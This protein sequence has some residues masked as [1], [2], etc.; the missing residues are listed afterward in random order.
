[1]ATQL[2]FSEFL[3]R[4]RARAWWMLRPLILRNPPRLLH[5][6]RSQRRTFRERFTKLNDTIIFIVPGYN[7][8]NGGI[9]SI[10]SIAAEVERLVNHHGAQVLICSFPGDPPLARFT[11]FTHSQPIFPLD[12][13]LKS[14]EAGSLVQIHIPEYYVHYFGGQARRLKRV[15]PDL[16]FCFN[17]M[18][19]NVDLAPSH[20]DVQHLAAVGVVTATTAHKA[21][22][23][24]E[25]ARKLGCRLWHWSTFISPEGYERRSLAR[26]RR[27]IVVS[28]D[29][30][31]RRMEVLRELS[32]RLPTFDLVVIR[33]LKYEMYKALIR[34]AMFSLTFGEGLDGYFVETIFSGGIGCAVFNDRFFSEEYVRLPF[35]YPDWNVL[36]Q[37]LA[38]DILR[39]VDGRGFEDAQR[40]QYDV[41]AAEYGYDKYV[42]NLRRY[43]AETNLGWR[44]AASDGTEEHRPHL[45]AK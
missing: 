39:S 24:I 26:K 22:A 16:E 19:Q 3:S 14:V 36:L 43:Y 42:S 8:V 17:V 4:N 41:V 1:M 6:R 29:E 40:W 9:L 38:E 27:L 45:G 7:I 2:T 23:S 34:D 15:F 30:H 21:Y 31:P 33:N 20:D 28:P 5:V 25:T 18:L 12:L 37:K 11:G 44:C 32:R 13:V 10:M 35:V